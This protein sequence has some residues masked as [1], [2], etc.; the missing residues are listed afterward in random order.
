MVFVLFIDIFNHKR[1][2]NFGARLVCS[3]SIESYKCL[4]CAFKRTCEKEASVIVTD[5]DVALLQVVLFVFT[6]TRHRLCM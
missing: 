5:Q 4:L 1:C 2:A 3:E 6:T